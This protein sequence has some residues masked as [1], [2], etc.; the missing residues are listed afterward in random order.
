MEKLSFINEY[1][2]NKH[3]ARNIFDNIITQS[4]IMMEILELVSSVLE[5]DTTILI[6]GETGTGKELFANVLHSNSPRKNG[7]FV[8]V[9][10][11]TIP[12]ELFESELFGIVKGAFTGASEN[13]KGLF[14][15]ADEG[16]LLLD[17]IGE[18]PL[19][20]QPKLLRVI[21]EKKVKS[22]GSDK[23]VDIDVRIIAT[24]NRDLESEVQKGN[25]REDLFYRLNVFPINLPPLRER[26]NDITLFANFFLKK[27][28]DRFNKPI[29]SISEAGMQLLIDYPWP[30]NVR[31]LENII[32]RA[33]ILEKKDILNNIE[34][35][36]TK[37]KAFLVDLEPSFKTS[38]NKTVEE[39]EKS[40]IFG[41]LEQH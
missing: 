15:T 9:N 24:T 2:I 12:D 14:Q 31:E 27:F 16:T 35:F 6:Q 20:I 22:L 5:Y 17:E 40:Y 30:G 32:E 7:P 29:K 34:C 13:R 28:A 39:F 25:F 19:K 36:L 41:L 38:K 26:K 21:E 1:R 10:C 37:K 18:M 3:Y 4:D 33:F 8:A 11:T 23:N